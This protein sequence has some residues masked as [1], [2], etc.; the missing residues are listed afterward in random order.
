MSDKCA[1]TYELYLT[2]W[3]A[4]SD[5]ERKRLLTASLAETMVFT[6]Q[7]KTRRGRLEVEEHL[8]GFQAKSPGASFRFN[9]M[10]GWANHALA[11]WQLVDAKGMPGFSGY[12]V[13]T[14]NDHGLID[15]ILMFVNVEGQKIVWRRR[16]PVSLG[17]T[18]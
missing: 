3:S 18:Q 4:V 11:E 12:D 8:I 14:L 10:V 5:G 6:N 9:N 16:D 13:V 2:A 1:R 15:A 17:P 7:Q